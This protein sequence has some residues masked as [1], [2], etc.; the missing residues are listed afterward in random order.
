MGATDGNVNSLSC[1]LFYFLIPVLQKHYRALEALALGRE[2]PEEFVDNSDPKRDG[3][4]TDPIRQQA[5]TAA[6]AIF[7]P[8]YEPAVAA[9]GKPAS[10]AKRRTAAAGGGGAAAAKRARPTEPAEP[11][12]DAAMQEKYAGNKVSPAGQG[13]NGRM[14]RKLCTP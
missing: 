9:S 8:G 10:G 6:E 14:M 11:V 5:R 12:D 1:Q 13:S 7:P 2:E 4:F 3:Y